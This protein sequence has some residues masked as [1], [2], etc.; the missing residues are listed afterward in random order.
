MKTQRYRFD[1]LICQTE[2]QI[3]IIPGVV[4]F[5]NKCFEMKSTTISKRPL[6]TTMAAMPNKVTTTSKQLSFIF[7]RLILGTI[8]K[9]PGGGGGDLTERYD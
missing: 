8:Y 9:C 4:K 7:S 6:P 3:Q 1:W 2:L 5:Q